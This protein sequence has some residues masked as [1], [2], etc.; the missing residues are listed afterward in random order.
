MNRVIR[1]RTIIAAGLAV[2][3]L[4]LTACSSPATTST[5]AP[6]TATGTTPSL[7]S[8]ALALAAKAGC[9]NPADIATDGAAGAFPGAPYVGFTCNADGTSAYVSVFGSHADEQANLAYR[10]ANGGGTLVTG[11]N[12]IANIYNDDPQTWDRLLD[13]TTN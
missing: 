5:S 4:A 13:E 11:S 1:V 10:T 7:M 2:A 9:P 8:T 12:F 3:G 6:A